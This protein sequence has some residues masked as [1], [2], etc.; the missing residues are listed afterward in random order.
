MNIKLTIDR[1]EE[2]KA[3]LKT[4]DNQTIIWPKD[5]LPAE[6]HEGTVVAFNIITDAEEEKSR[7]EQAKEILNE[8][9]SVDE[10]EEK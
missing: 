9:L 4:D 5:K 2:D 3:V 8:I 10:D 1:F 7:K 6:A